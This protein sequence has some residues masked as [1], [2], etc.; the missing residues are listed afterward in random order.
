MLSKERLSQLIQITTDGK[1]L[2]DFVV[3]AIQMDIPQAGV[4][5]KF[6]KKN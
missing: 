1:M 2:P 4:A 6:G 5:R 3:I